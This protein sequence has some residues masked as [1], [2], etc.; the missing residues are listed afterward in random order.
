MIDCQGV[1]LAFQQVRNLGL[2]GQEQKPSRQEEQGQLF[3]LC[4]SRLVL[5]K[6]LKS[7]LIRKDRISYLQ[8]QVAEA[9]DPRLTHRSYEQNRTLTQPACQN[10]A[11]TCMFLFGQNQK[12]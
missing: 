1:P 12:F 11:L 5:L 2:L 9:G 4:H 10:L 8:A 6:P 7:R 3:V